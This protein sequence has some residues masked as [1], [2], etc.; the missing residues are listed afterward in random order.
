MHFIL[1]RGGG[2]WFFHIPFGSIAKFESLA[3][4]P[5]DYLSFLVIPCLVL[6][7]YKFARF[8]YFVINLFICVSPYPTQAILVP[9]IN[10]R[11]DEIGPNDI[12]LCN[13]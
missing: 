1:K 6:I 3:Q 9:I 8:V 5:V 11:F 4:F 13:R 12:I 10:F 2:F 7:L